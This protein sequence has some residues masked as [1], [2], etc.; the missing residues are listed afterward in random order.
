MVQLVLVLL[1]TVNTDLNH[2][3]ALCVNTDVICFIVPGDSIIFEPGDL[4]VGQ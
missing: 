3:F 1:Y 4:N 2:I